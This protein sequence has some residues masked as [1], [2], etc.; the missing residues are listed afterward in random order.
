MVNNNSL[1]ED[2]LPKYWVYMLNMNPIYLTKLVAGKKV[3]FLCI[4]RPRMC[5]YIY[6]SGKTVWASWGW[7]L[8]LITVFSLWKF[9]EFCKLENESLLRCIPVSAVN[10]WL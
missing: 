1:D 6:F 10:I 4:L 9:R 3:L 5:I 2:K 7:Q 8:Q